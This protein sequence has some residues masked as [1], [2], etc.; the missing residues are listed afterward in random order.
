MR[1]LLATIGTRGDVQ[2]Y[3]ALAVGLLTAGHEVALATCERY[4]PWIRRFGITPLPLDD[5]LLTLLESPAGRLLIG[6]LD[7]V[8]GGVTAAASVL[9][10]VRPMNERLVADA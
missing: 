1:I 3:L 2:P 4:A 10:D 7:S 8:W 9:R 6:Q 5:S